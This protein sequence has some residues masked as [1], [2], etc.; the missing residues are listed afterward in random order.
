MTQAVLV[1]GGAGYVGSHTCKALAQAGYQPVTFDNLIC[2]HDWAVKWGPLEHGDIRNTGRLREVIAAHNPSTVIHFAAYA[3]AAESVDEPEKYYQNNLIGLLSLL[4][5][6]RS[7]NLDR[8][9]FS[10]TCAVYGLPQAVPVTEDHPQEAISPYGAS[11][12]M[13]ERI[14]CDHGAAYDLHFISLRYFNAAGADPDG[15]IGECHNPETHLV[16]SVLDAALGRRLSLTVFGNDYDTPDG[17]CIR[18]YVHV[19]DLAKA[20]LLALQALENGGENT[21]Y[22]LGSGTGVSVKEIIDQAAAVTGRQI[23]VTVG[24]RRNGDPPQLVASVKKAKDELG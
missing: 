14:I 15:E 6:M 24:P 22:N 16:P 23:G 7:C 3:Y 10:S 17:T 4:E 12:A 13:G 11:K 21:V 18:D 2:G 9:V 19:T 8:L 20:H 1:T 5:A